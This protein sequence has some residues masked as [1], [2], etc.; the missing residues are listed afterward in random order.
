MKFGSPTSYWISG[1]YFPQGFMTGCLQRHSRRYSIPIDSLKVDF[2]LTDTVLIQEDI[3]AVRATDFQK[4]QSAYKGLTK[5]EDGVYVHGLFLDAGRIDLNTKLLVDPIPGNGALSRII[6][7]DV[8]TNYVKY[9]SNLRS[10][11]SSVARNT[12][13]ADRSFRRKTFAVQMSAVQNRHQSGSPFNY[14]TQ[15]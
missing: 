14:W 2:E 13:R 7:D 6:D 15:Y 4:K 1:L 8:N 5:Q 11:V 3:A 10:P 9:C 12:T